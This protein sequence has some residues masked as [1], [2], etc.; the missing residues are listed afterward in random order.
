MRSINVFECDGSV[1]L[2]TSIQPICYLQ[3]KYKSIRKQ[4]LS[5]M[6]LTLCNLARTIN[7]RAIQKGIS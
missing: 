6:N 4:I 1:R 3:W 7:Y 2:L 5:V